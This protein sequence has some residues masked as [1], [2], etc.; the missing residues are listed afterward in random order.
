MDEAFVRRLHFII[1]F[2]LPNDF[3]RRRIWKKVFLIQAPSFIDNFVTVV[4]RIII[5]VKQMLA[6]NTP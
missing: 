3:H 5:T 1:Q 4:I 2:L 6:P